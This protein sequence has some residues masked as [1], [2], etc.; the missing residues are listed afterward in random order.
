MAVISHSIRVADDT[1]SSF[2]TAFTRKFAAEFASAMLS[3]ASISFSSK[4][5]FKV[6]AID[7][8]IAFNKFVLRKTTR[9]ILI[10]LSESI[11]ELL[12]FLLSHEVLDHK[13]KGGLFDLVS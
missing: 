3:R 11:R 5:E 4:F 2:A 13:T 6:V 8:S 1:P 10:K 12:S 7:F 9:A